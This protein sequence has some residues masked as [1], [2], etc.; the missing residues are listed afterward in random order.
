MAFADHLI[1]VIGLAIEANA[2]PSATAARYFGISN[3]LDIGVLDAALDGIKTTDRW[4]KRAVRELASD[5]RA[6]RLG[7]ARAGGLETVCDL[8]AVRDLITEIRALPTIGLAALQIAAR[9]ISRLVPARR[10]P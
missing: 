2:D 10:I 9:A 1:D 8:S 6:S 3:L 7:L 4:E 5:L